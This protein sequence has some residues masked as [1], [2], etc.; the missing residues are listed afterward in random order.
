MQEICKDRPVCKKDR[1]KNS[2]KA[3]KGE[4]IY[5]HLDVTF[6]TLEK[7]ATENLNIIRKWALGI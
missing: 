2:D 6:R 1:R 3:V 7:T 5:W 4:S